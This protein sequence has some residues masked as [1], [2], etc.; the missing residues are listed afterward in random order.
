MYLL[1]TCALLWLATDHAQLSPKATAVLLSGDSVLHFSAISALEIERL[2]QSGRVAMKLAADE[3]LVKLA[4]RYRLLELPVDCRIAALAMRL[5][6]IHKDPCDR[7]IIATAA[8]HRLKI[9]T[10]DE[11]IPR[12]AEARV[13][14]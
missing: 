9:V 1:D 2:R 12:Y 3:W 4:N 14:W 11:T 13:V 10:R 6:P 5:P 7:L 8:I